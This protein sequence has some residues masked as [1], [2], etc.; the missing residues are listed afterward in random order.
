MKSVNDI[1]FHYLI[2]RLSIFT[3]TQKLYQQIE[4]FKYLF[5]FVQQI[6]IFTPFV[7]KIN[8]KNIWHKPIY[9]DF[10]IFSGRLM[11][12]NLRII[13]HSI[14]MP[15]ANL[16][17]FLIFL[18]SNLKLAE[19]TSFDLKKN[20]VEFSVHQIKQLFYTFSE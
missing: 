19:H 11:V 6:K 14:E 10:C 15:R 12:T 13:W 1:Y 5:I 9:I 20:L 3:I 18:F 16:C 4:M 7:W 8:N 2:S 17:K